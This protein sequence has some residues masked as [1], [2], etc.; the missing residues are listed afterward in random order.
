MRAIGSNSGVAALAGLLWLA[1]CAHYD[2]PYYVHSV[3]RPAGGAAS[4]VEVFYVTDRKPNAGMAGGFSYLPADA[5][6]CGAIGMEIPAAKLPAGD[7]AFGTVGKPEPSAC[8]ASLEAL[9]ARVADAAHAVHCARTLIFVHGFYTGFETA[10][11]RTGQLKSDAA[12]ACPAIAFSWTSSGKNDDYQGDEAASRKAEPLFAALV[13]D[14]AARG[15]RPEIV[16]HSLGARLALDG[17]ASLASGGESGNPDLAGELMLYA[18]DVD[19]DAFAR[20]AAAVAPLVQRITIYASDE[21]SALA[22][23][24]RLHD[25]AARLGRQPD[26]DRRFAQ[27]GLHCVDVIDASDAPADIDGHDYYGLSYEVLS[28]MALTLAGVPAAARTRPFFGRDPTL[29]CGEQP[30]GPDARFALNVSWGRRPGP[31]LRFIRWLIPL[32]PLT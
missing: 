27:P 13:R 19:H 18:A 11:L 2:D 30:C 7:D 26:A 24:A 17:L 21:D 12:F 20:K 32:L 31:I 25:G 5:P 6:S 15:I 9:A 8:G 3:W 28:D 10:A 29:T 16:A 4:H 23:S 1:G 22:L 14:L